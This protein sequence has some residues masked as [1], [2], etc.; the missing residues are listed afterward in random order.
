MDELES[1]IAK[2]QLGNNKTSSSYVFVM[3]EKAP[4]SDAELYV[5]ADM[6][7][8]N[9]AAEESCERIC[10]AIASGLKRSYRKAV[11]EGSFENA[12]S[13]I[14]EELGKLAGLG[15]TQW[16]NKLNCVLGVK[17]GNEFS[18]ATCGKVSAYLLRN[19]EYTDISCSP[20]Q[21]HPLK[22]F[23]NYATGKIR[24]GDLL[25]LSTTQMFNYLSMDR[26]L[27]I[28]S[29]SDF[30]TAT[31]TVIQLLKETA[32]PQITFGVLLNLQVPPGQAQEEEQDLEN[33]IVEQPTG[34]N[35]LSRIFSYGKTAFGMDKAVRREPQVALPKISFGQ[36]L[37]NLQ[38]NTQN[39]MAKTLALWHSAKS[40]A[41]NVK[42]TVNPQNLKQLSTQKKF[43]LISALILLIAVVA[44][45][46][47][48][49]HLK[50]TRAVQG[51]ISG[52]L[53]EAQNLLTSAQGSLLYKDDAAAAAYLLQA[54]AKIPAAN[55]IDSA[56]KNLYNKVLAQVAAT[57]TLMEKV[58]TPTVTNLGSLG[59]GDSLIKLPNYE[60][61]QTNQVIVSYN[62]TNS[63]VE[64]SALASSVAIA[65]SAFLSGNTAAIYDG[66]N[67]YQWDFSKGA[68]GA[69]FPAGG[70]SASG[71]N[72][73][74]PQKNDFGGMAQYPTN[75]RI[76]I[77]DK[78]LGQ[79]ISFAPTT[80]TFSKP[81]VAARDNSLNNALDIAIDGNIYVLTKNG[82]SKFQSGAPVAFTLSLPKP[83]SGSGKIAAQK[84]FNFIYLLDTGNN[85]ILILDKKGTLINTLKSDR[86]TK[87][88]DFQVDEKGKVIYVLNDGSLLK[89][90]LP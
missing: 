7:L 60:G 32:D 75:S 90:S 63:K 10:L 45:I 19:N 30:L 11:D 56:D 68:L 29:G 78:K 50:N 8:F 52:R 26:L 27:N 66:S 81:I 16:I 36:K 88:K 77:V 58:F 55:K 80:N 5:V 84:D 37:K 89:V 15:Q 41:E 42:Q 28:V 40:S 54:K 62:K 6:P 59:Q 87:L 82:I 70:G 69:G 76:Y 53:K 44:N 79:I 9:P 51:Q 23:E 1:Q 48:A 85:T 64:D 83:F 38:G 2:I 71:G 46:G 72:S 31:K 49:A 3:A 13:Q 39:L 12:T 22:T 14:N 74:L 73:S 61:V 65:G 33:Y 67:L 25:I 4:G 24:L 21:S 86:F 43:F 20:A 18:I 47:I 57:Q 17:H 35:I 34:E